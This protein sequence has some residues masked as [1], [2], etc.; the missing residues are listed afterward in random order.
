MDYDI[1]WLPRAIYDAEKRLREAGG[2][3]S[4]IYVHPWL[5][6]QLL[7]HRDAL[8]PPL[9]EFPSTLCGYPYEV[10]CIDCDFILTQDKEA[11]E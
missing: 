6:E 5:F 9:T 7:A 11:D 3:P 8:V 1:S 4:K 10:A 2:T